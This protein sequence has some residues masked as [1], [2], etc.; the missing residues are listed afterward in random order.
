V[1]GDAG[2]QILRQRLAPLALR[3]CLL[4]FRNLAERNAAAPAFTFA[5]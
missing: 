2:V 3:A 5:D 1:P 4:R